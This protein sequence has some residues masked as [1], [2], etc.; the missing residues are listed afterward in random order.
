MS[1]S[2]STKTN[3]RLR[4]TRL[5]ANVAHPSS[6]DVECMD[7][8]VAQIVHAASQSASVESRRASARPCRCPW[9]ES[10]QTQHA[11][12]VLALG[13]NRASEILSVSA[14]PAAAEARCDNLLDFPLGEIWPTKLRGDCLVEVS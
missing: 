12:K 5:S 14:S 3:V 7:Y 9:K 13:L 1:F 10:F 6:A 11:A 2:L 8:H 4:T